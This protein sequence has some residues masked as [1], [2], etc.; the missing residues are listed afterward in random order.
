MKTRIISIMT[1]VIFAILVFIYCQETQA[2]NNYAASEKVPVLIGFRHTP[3]PS[4]QAVVRSHGGEIKY[5]YNIVPAIAA[6]LPQ[7]ALGALSKNPNV[8]R[9]EPDGVLYYADAELDNSWGVKRIGA[10]F[11]HDTGNE[12]DG[13][14]IAI[15]DS[16]V[17]YTHPDLAENYGGGYDFCNN[18]DDPMD[19]LG[20]G[21]H[22][23]GIVAALDN[24]LRR[25]VVGVAPKAI[26]FA[27]KVGGS[28]GI[29]ESDVIE[30]LNWIV[31]YNADQNNT[32]KIRVTNNS[33]GRHGLDYNGIF[34]AA[35]D[36]TYAL[37]VLHV[38]AAGNEGSYEKVSYP[39]LYDSCIAVGAT[40][41]TD[42]IASFSN[43]GE[44]I[45]LAAPGVGINSTILGGRYG[46]KS[47]T[48]M[49]SP[50]VAGAAALIW[51][52]YPDWTN[53]DVRM[54]LDSTA[55][56]LGPP[57]GNSAYGWGLVDAYSAASIPAT[58]VYVDSITYSTG[59][60][61][62]R[63]DLNITVALKDDFGSPV[64][65]ALVSIE[66]YLGQDFYPEATNTTGT[67]GKV[68]FTI[69]NA[70]SGTYITTVTDVTAYGLT[71]DL[72]YPTNS[73]RK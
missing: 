32:I 65:D 67:D 73:F 1:F 41:G 55:V 58:E 51:F 36:N 11:I 17:D 21:T 37:G 38:C 12:G 31:A 64:S 54:Q 35:F 42:M 7:S 28:T 30:A 52:A 44:G 10:G 14:G 3:G 46:T 43:Q 50:H 4:E 59:R 29:L 22:V 71:W 23:A 20:H 49:A 57:E 72:M 19:D 18:D 33:Y 9:I 40:D 8:T 47:G 5:S 16:G 15:I 25:S 60:G 6:S 70:P 62:N 66:I 45:E 24:N 13:V 63:N 34:K 69:S 68:I 2:N 56:D 39:A 48:S 27:L 53:E 61:K 26:I